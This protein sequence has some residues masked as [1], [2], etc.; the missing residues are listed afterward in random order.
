[1]LKKHE[2][3]DRTE[4]PVVCRDTR[5]AQGN[6]PVVCSSS[7]TRRLGDAS[8]QTDDTVP[9]AICAATAAP[10]PVIEHVAPAPAVPHVASS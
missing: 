4:K 10:A 5:R 8:T 3:Y 2:L 9:A 6:G 7:Y 1:M